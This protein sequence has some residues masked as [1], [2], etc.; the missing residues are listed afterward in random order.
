MVEDLIDDLTLFAVGIVAP[1]LIV[2]TLD[3][4]QKNKGKRVKYHIEYPR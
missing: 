3:K 4:A 2:L 1:A